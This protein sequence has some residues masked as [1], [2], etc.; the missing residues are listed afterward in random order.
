MLV[1]SH[2]HLA[3][4]AFAED[5]E[6]VVARM[7]EAGVRRAVLIES[8]TAQLE[9]T[10]DWAARHSGLVVA[11]GCHPHDASTWSPALADRVRAAWAHPLVR[12]AGEM[13]LDYHYDF[14]PRATQQAVF[15]EQLDL[16]TKAGLPVVIHARDADD[17]VVAILK[18]QPDATIILHSFS[19]G[20]TLRAAGL[21]GGWYFSFSGMVTFRS[22]TDQDTMRAVAAERLL[23]ETD[24]PYLAPVPYR[25]KRNE[26][27]FVV[28]V[29]RMLA[30]V[31]GTTFEE[32]AARTTENAMRLFWPE[33]QDDR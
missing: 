1:D 15:A 29:A 21:E 20:P 12:A 33:A 10:L 26:P 27:S 24:A 30:E 13:G 9:Q 6:A 28:E 7:A 23:V 31:R 25:G 11:T 5:R 16:A 3:D 19:S 22:W 18:N 2:C 4:P 14:S 32:I 17:D 8:V